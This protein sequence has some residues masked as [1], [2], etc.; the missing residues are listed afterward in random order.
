M[1]ATKQAPQTQ[2]HW[3]NPK[4]DFKMTNAAFSTWTHPATGAVRIYINAAAFGST[5]VWVE[6]CAADAFGYTYTIRARNDNRSRSE[7]NNT[8]NDVEDIITAVFGSRPKAFEQVLS[9]AK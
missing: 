4:K 7:L 5:K 8:I 9:L 6:Q 1:Q 3:A 2:R